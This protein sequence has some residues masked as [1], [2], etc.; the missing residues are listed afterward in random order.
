MAAPDGNLPVFPW[1]RFLP[2]MVAGVALFFLFLQSLTT[3]LAWW[4]GTLAQPDAR[5]WLWIGLMPVCLY[6]LFLDFPRRM[7]RLRTACRAHR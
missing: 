3:T 7:P 1:R 2:G 6:P 5:D 4:R